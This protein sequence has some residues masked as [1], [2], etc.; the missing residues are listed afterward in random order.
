MQTDTKRTSVML[1]AE[2]HERL[3]AQAREAERPLGGG[4]PPRRPRA[5]R[6]D[7][8]PQRRW[9]AHVQ[10]PR[11]AK[12]KGKTEWLTERTEEAADIAL[13][14]AQIAKKAAKKVLD[15]V[16]TP[17]PRE[18]VNYQRLSGLEQ[19]MLARISP[20]HRNRWPELRAIRR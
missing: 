18:D 11:R 13:G 16:P 6:D 19:S 9:C 5:H 1:P 12:V 14:S 17:D 20:R 2:I 15:A 10:R 7:R 3:S 4:D 8:G